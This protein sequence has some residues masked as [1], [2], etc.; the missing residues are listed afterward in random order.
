MATVDSKLATEFVA[1][2]HF[3][4]GREHPLTRVT[5]HHAVMVGN[6]RMVAASFRGTDKKS[7]TYAIGKSAIQPNFS[8]R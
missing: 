4:K 6:A 2:S 1:S 8:V 7:A 3:R 5:I